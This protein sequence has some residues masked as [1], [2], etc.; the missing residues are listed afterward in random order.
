MSIQLC[1]RKLGVV[2]D[3]INVIMCVFKKRTKNRATI[4]QNGKAIKTFL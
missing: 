3:N 1:D 2:K 4:F